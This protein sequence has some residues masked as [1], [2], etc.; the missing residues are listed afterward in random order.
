MEITIKMSKEEKEV[1]ELAEN[2]RVKDATLKS[3]LGVVAE[4]KVL[5]DLSCAISVNFPDG[6]TR[7]LYENYN[8]ADFGRKF[9]KLILNE[10][11]G[12]GIMKW[13][14]IIQ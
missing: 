11:A 7:D 12:M 3:T 5:P 14:N 13:F 4:I 10:P 1:F 6:F 9:M 8:F 2:E